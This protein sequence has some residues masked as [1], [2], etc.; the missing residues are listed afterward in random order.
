[1]RKTFRDAFVH[2]NELFA[3]DDGQQDKYYA[4]YE[5][6]TGQRRNSFVFSQ[7]DDNA[8]DVCS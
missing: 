6:Q 3:F 1:M 4:R 5:R 8:G 2:W 7:Y